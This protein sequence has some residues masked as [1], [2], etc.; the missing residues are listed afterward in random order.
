MDGKVR[1]EQ[2]HLEGLMAAFAHPLVRVE[3]VKCR[4][5]RRSSPAFFLPRARNAA[6]LFSR[7]PF[8]PSPAGA[9][10]G[11]SPTAEGRQTACR[12]S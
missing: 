8:A 5:G 11:K 3:E 7:H 12:D 4:L 6:K 1:L 10:Y 2:E 9:E